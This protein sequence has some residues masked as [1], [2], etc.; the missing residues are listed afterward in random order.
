MASLSGAN[1]LV[2]LPSK[3]PGGPERIEA[4]ELVDAVIIGEIQAS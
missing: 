2:A 3:V 4:G 1:G